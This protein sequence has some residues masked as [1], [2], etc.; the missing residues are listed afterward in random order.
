VEGEGGKV[1]DRYSFLGNC[2]PWKEA[3]N[4]FERGEKLWIDTL[5]SREL[6]ETQPLSLVRRANN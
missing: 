5:S 3:F 1:L 4:L 2:F 6:L